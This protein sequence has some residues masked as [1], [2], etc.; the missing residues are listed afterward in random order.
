MSFK[1]LTGTTLGVQ[2]YIVEVEAEISQ[3]LPGFN[4][5]GLPDAEVKESKE[6]V[7]AAIR[8]LGIRNFAQRITVNLAPANLK[9]EGTQFDLPI[10]LAIL[11]AAGFIKDEEVKEAVF[12]G[13]LSLNGELRN[14]PGVLPVALLLKDSEKKL[15]VPAGNGGEASLVKEETYEANSLADVLSFIKEG[16]ELH[17]N[18]KKLSPRNN[19]F[20]DF[21]EVKGQAVAKRALEIAASG[22]HHV[23]MVGPPGAGKTLLASRFPSILPPMTEEE[24]VETTLVYSVAGLLNRN[25]IISSRPFRAPHHTSSDVAIVGGGSPPKPGEI[26]LAHNGVLFLDELPEFKRKVLEVLREPL[27]TGQILISRAEWKF[28][29]PARFQLI[30]AMNPCPCGYFTHPKIACRC[31]PREIKSYRAKIS[32]PMLDRID[33][34]IELPPPEFSELGGKAGENSDKIRSRVM[35]SKEFSRHRFKKEN[36]PEIKTNANIP[37]NL[38]EKLCR[39]TPE[40]EALLKEAFETLLPSARAY[41]K[42]LRVARTIA[43]MRKA[44]IIDV[45]DVTEALS[46]RMLEKE[47]W[48]GVAI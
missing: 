29:F 33:I 13:E 30:A 3:G 7:K 28:T 44:D 31:S 46:Y 36:H 35:E 2:G 12:L 1:V 18:S 40:A 43:D 26:S 9:K 5:V 27:E 45:E 37:P 41:H 20:G 25:E 21:N 14:V 8:N 32:G 47:F 15:I 34:H 19:Y 48:F 17:K 24:M 42:T 10:A 23:I 11:G 16:K 4:I 39:T 6:R 38:I 22:G